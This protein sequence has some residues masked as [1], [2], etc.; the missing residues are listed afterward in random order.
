MDGFDDYGNGWYIRK[1][2]SRLRRLKQFKEK[3]KELDRKL[4]LIDKII[5]RGVVTT[6]A[7]TE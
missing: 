6:D 1:D 5:Q 3:E 2:L 4:A 7:S